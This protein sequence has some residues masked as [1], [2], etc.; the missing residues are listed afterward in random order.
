MVGLFGTW[1]WSILGGEWQH[2]TLGFVIVIAVLVNLSTWRA[3]RGL[4]MVAWQAA[5]ARLPLRCVG[6]GTRGGRPIE[7]AHDSDRARMILFLSIATSAVVIAGLSFL[8]IPS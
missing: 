1:L 5:L 3:C 2:A 8:L 4:P 6:F 7:A